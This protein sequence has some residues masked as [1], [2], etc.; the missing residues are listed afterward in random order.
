MSSQPYAVNAKFSILPERREEFLKIIKE[1][2]KQTL[3][4]E[5]GALRFVVGED[6]KENNTFYLHEEYTSEEAFE[7]HGTTPHYGPWDK[8]TKSGPWAKG[9]EPVVGLF[10]GTHQLGDKEE[11]KSGYCVN[12]KVSIVPERREEFL[13]IIKEDQKLTLA[14]EPGSIQF[15]VGEDKES[16]NTFYLFEQYENEEAFGAHGKAPHY[17][18]WD[19]FVKTNPWSEGGEPVV[20]L[21]NTLE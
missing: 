11:V 9:G 5:P 6:P 8:F 7:A 13:N 20:G 17:A 15:V 3:A 14:N 4:T 2:Q 16:T 19:A 12:A 18:P 21:Y 10:H 1:D